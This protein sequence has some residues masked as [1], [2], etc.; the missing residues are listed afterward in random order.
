MY[1][2]SLLYGHRS[3]IVHGGLLSTLLD[4]GLARP[5]FFAL[6]AKLGVTANLNVDFKSPCFAESV[7]PEHAT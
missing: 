2:S 3:G 6:P 4:E 5:A 1:L 7:S